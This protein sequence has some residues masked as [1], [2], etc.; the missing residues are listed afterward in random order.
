M[1][2]LACVNK[3]NLKEFALTNMRNVVENQELLLS[4]LF[5][6]LKDK[7]KNNLSENVSIQ[8]KLQTCLQECKDV[9]YV[10]D[11]KKKSN[12]IIR[13]NDQQLLTYCKFKQIAAM[14]NIPVKFLL[15]ILFDYFDTNKQ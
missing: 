3:S 15:C 6:F 2:I 11:G 5:A 4:N 13:V 1:K 10:N 14:Y 7:S 12:L 9:Y 8:Q